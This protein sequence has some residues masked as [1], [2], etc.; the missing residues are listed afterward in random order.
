MKDTISSRDLHEMFRFGFTLLN[1][2]VDPA[3]IELVDDRDQDDGAGNPDQGFGRVFH[4]LRIIGDPYC[5]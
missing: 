4:L 3:S 1:A 5:R 2:L